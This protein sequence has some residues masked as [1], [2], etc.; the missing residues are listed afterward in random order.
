MLSRVVS[1]ILQFIMLAASLALLF[2]IVAARMGVFVTYK[3][4]FRDSGNVISTQELRRGETPAP[5]SPNIGD[6][7]VFSHWEDANGE[8]TDPFKLPAEGDKV[9]ECNT[10]PALTSEH[11]IWLGV[12]GY[13]IRPDEPV[14][15]TEF[16]D[17]MERLAAPGALEYF[18]TLPVGERALDASDLRRV[19][20]ELPMTSA[21]DDFLSGLEG[22][23][24]RGEVAHAIN[25]LLGRDP[26]SERVVPSAGAHIYF[27]LRPEHEY[28]A[29]LMEASTAHEPSAYG[30]SWATVTLERPMEAGLSLMEGALYN[31]GED[32]YPICDAELGTLYFGAD[33]KQTSGDA[34]LDGYVRRVIAELEPCE[35]ID[36]LR[37][38][39]NYTRD[40]F[41]YLRG[42]IYKGGDT[43]WE[44]NEAKAM[45]ERGRGNCYSFAAT[46]WALS[47]GLGYDATAY[48]G[49]I[50]K[51]VQPHGWVRIEFDGVNYFFDPET[52]YAYNKKGD[53]AH[54]MFM[55]PP[56]TAQQ[57]S[58]RQ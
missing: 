49:Y 52:E 16:K 38:A 2:V 18:P 56:V 33:G 43:G 13:Y 39:Y 4:E 54:D 19:L 51:A 28:Y 25:A 45:F 11:I 7:R 57:W 27:D 6:E 34:E 12:D 5:V 23:V 32:G 21:V 55:L 41:E 14:S 30:K 47:R 35:R 9:Y 22:E 15:C 50:S 31:I 26:L 53:Y 1:F 3:I 58:Y 48:S 44:V 20:G 8:P 40:S 36:M 37:A 24:T 42:S 10:K 29:D 17:I 46:F